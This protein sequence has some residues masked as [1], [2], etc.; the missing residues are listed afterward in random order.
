MFIVYNILVFLQVLV[1]EAFVNFFLFNALRIPFFVRT[2]G[3]FLAPLFGGVNSIFCWSEDEFGK[4]NEAGSVPFVE[5][6]HESHYL[7][8]V[9]R[10]PLPQLSQSVVNELFP[11]IYLVFLIE[12]SHI[13]HRGQLKEDE[14][15]RK[16]V[17]FKNIVGHV[18]SVSAFL[19]MSSP[20]DGT[21]VLWCT[22]NSGH[23]PNSSILSV[24]EVIFGFSEVN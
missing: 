10:V 18:P 16:N 17:R 23:G 11:I 2:K 8:Y 20:K 9:I 6:K 15:T 14:P 21:Q 22:P 7:D 13:L 4:L 12:A 1:T 24:L 5:L 19:N 3:L